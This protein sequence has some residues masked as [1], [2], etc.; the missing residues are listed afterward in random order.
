MNLMI[1]AVY[2]GQFLPDYTEH[3]PKNSCVYTRRYGNLKSRI[4]VL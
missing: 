4:V 1:E 3:Y 2:I